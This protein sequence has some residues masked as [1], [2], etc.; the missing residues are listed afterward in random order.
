MIIIVIGSNVMAQVLGCHMSKN[1]VWALGR[2]V[3]RTLAALVMGIMGMG[4]L[5]LDPLYLFVA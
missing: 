5:D 1:C 3:K 2:W 4:L